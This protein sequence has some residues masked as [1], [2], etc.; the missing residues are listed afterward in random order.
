MKLL[1]V[2]ID[3]L[4]DVASLDDGLT[5][6]ERAKRP[7]LNRLSK[8]GINGLI[9]PVCVGLACGS[10][11]AHLS[12]FGLAPSD[13]YRG[14][15]SFECMGA[16]L[17]MK[18]GDI[19]FKSNFA[20]M[21]DQSIV[22]HR[23]ADRRFHEWGKPLCE[24]LDGLKLPN[25][26]DVDVSVRYATEH[27]CGVRLRGDGLSD[28]ISGTDPLKDGRLLL[29]CMPTDS[30]II[31]S[32][33][34]S[35][36]AV[37]TSAIVN[38]LSQVIYQTLLNHPIN[39]KRRENGEASTNC[40]LL[41][42]AGARIDVPSFDSLHHRRGFA[43]APTAIIGGLA[44]TIGLTREQVEGATGDYDTDLI[45][46][47]DAVV[48]L[49]ESDEYEFGFLHVKAVDDAG[50]DSNLALK[51]HWIER[52]DEMVERCCQQLKKSN[53][54]YMIIVA[55]DHSTPARLGDHSHEP[56]PCIITRLDDMQFD[57]KPFQPCDSSCAG[58]Q[59]VQLDRVQSYGELSS[60]E[61][62]LGR[63]KGNELLRTAARFEMASK[64]IKQS[65]KQSDHSTIK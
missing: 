11:T 17:S 20:Y 32:N 64:C 46:K 30:S 18:P 47:A 9:D 7:C 8:Y 61:G 43:I 21:D 54:Q 33:D 62:V 22:L 37:R 39:V 56:V 52:C 53:N 59:L 12:L 40:V 10:D 27:R 63:F 1:F 25:Y 60:S 41:R 16:G 4:G 51:Q 29:K 65:I 57:D 45:A 24:A 23:R 28:E 15:G 31:Q 6:L 5:C 49:I 19:A 38:E 42:G 14:R 3:G 55:A 26:P 58:C 44:E 36:P 48:R 2:L 13:Y 50:H 34:M 35:I